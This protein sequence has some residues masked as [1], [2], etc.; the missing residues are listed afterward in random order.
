MKNLIEKKL[1][2]NDNEQHTAFIMMVG[3]CTLNSQLL[4]Y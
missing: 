1:E 4:S 3:K 2:M